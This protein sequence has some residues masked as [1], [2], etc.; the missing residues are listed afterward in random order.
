[1]SGKNANPARGSSDRNGDNINPHLRE[2][3]RSFKRAL[4]TVFVFSFFINVLMLAVPLYLLQIYSKVIPNHSVETLYFLTGIMVVAL[5]ALG[6]LSGI[7]RRILAKLGAWFENQLGDHLLGSAIRRSSKKRRP[8][9]DILRDL[10]RLGQFVSSSSVIAILDLPW[11]PVYIAVLYLL[12]PYLGLLVLLGVIVLLALAIA[13]QYVTRNIVKTSDAAR[14]ETLDSAASYVRN[15]DVIQAMGMQ[16][17]VLD[18]WRAQHDVS[19]ARSHE[20]SA[21]TARLASLAKLVRLLLQVAVICLSAWLILQAEM[22]GGSLIACVLLFRRAVSPLEQSIASWESVIKARSSLKNVGF[23]LDRAP[24]LETVESLPTPNGALSVE[25]VSY[26]HSGSRKAVLNRVTFQ[27]DPG[28]V[29]A[30]VGET[31]AGKST[32]T[33]ILVGLSAPASGRVTLD[34]FDL[35][36]WPPD[37]LGRHIGYLPQ[38]VELFPGTIRENIARLQDGDIDKVIEAA[39]LAN[40]HELIQRLPDG[41]DTDI[42]EDGNHLSGGQRQRIALARVFYGSPRLVVLDEPDANLDVDGRA[43]LVLA[44]RNLKEQGAI[45]ILITHQ[46][47]AHQFVDRVHALRNGALETVNTEDSKH[48]SVVHKLKRS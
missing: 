4:K 27:A 41:Y 28:D 38:D 9:T 33:R 23:Y 7:R 20:G 24:T 43:A 29:V 46:P 11:T 26:R 2:V 18:K 25:R 13:N 37:E 14:R 3:I 19:L 12:H 35:K 48:E 16:A 1:M 21:I 39:R 32:L 40:A 10:S 47:D 42:G 31:A 45:V 8:S 44:L 15:A 5:L 34:G 22:T 6:L 36:H 17:A 30:I